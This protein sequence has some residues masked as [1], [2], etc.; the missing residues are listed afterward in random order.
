M[1]KLIICCVAIVSTLFIGVFIVACNTNTTAH[2][3]HAYSTT[4][5]LDE[6][7]HW[8]ECSCGKIAEL[9]MHTYQEVQNSKYLK[10][11]ATHDQ[12]AVYY[13]S[14]ICGK[15]TTETFNGSKLPSSLAGKTF[16]IG[17]TDTKVEA[18][19]CKYETSIQKVETS[20]NNT[21][22]S[23]TAESLYVK[24]DNVTGEFANNTKGV[25]KISNWA[26]NIIFTEGCW[27]YNQNLTLYD[28]INDP[29][30]YT[31]LASS[32]TFDAYADTTYLFSYNPTIQSEQH[33]LV[34]MSDQNKTLAF[35]LQIFDSD[36]N[37][38][39]Y[40]VN[41]NYSNHTFSTDTICYIMVDFATTQPT[42]IVATNFSATSQSVGFDN[43]RLS[44]TMTM[45]NGYTYSYRINV[46]SAGSKL[47][48]MQTAG[49][50]IV[51]NSSG[52]IF[53]IKSGTNIY[54]L[55]TDYYTILVKCTNGSNEYRLQYSTGKY[56]AE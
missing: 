6:T 10:T 41:T 36:F 25:W 15:A 35:N 37:N 34:A 16:T 14:C 9:S 18:I 19:D 12:C 39:P 2:H 26:K 4:F 3:S 50:I 53:N 13:K 55:P 30:L 40:N 56:V 52:I 43:C 46:I 45:L 32:R 22:S 21:L 49:D 28:N 54:E 42:T 48:I 20:L 38:I 51:M 8:N 44:S 23:V 1:K 17:F 7:Q 33:L 47:Q 29:K 11:Q 24:L 27:T 31:S 5:C